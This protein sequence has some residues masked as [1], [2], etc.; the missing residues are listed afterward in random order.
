[1]I[2]VII[3]LITLLSILFTQLNHPLSM[4]LILLLQTIMICLSSGLSTSSF[5]FSYILFL[6]FLGGMLVLF[7]Y[8]A[9]IA[10]NENFLFSMSLFI[11]ISFLIFLL[12]LGLIFLDPLLTP[13][14][15][16][17]PESSIFMPYLT[18]T[19]NFINW[20]YS[21]PSMMFTLFIICYLLLTLFVVVKVTNM[22]LGPMRLTF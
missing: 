7:I 3:P 19:P 8:V 11:L 20:L 12:S 2:F 18:S 15:M 14:M 17:A 4:G 21:P 6:I 13:N 16:S 22:F 5:W 10:S 1:M 9:S